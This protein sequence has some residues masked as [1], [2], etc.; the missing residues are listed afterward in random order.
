MV[1]LVII[2]ALLMLFASCVTSSGGDGDTLENTHYTLHKGKTVIHPTPLP[3]ETPIL[4]DWFDTEGNMKTTNG[5]R[6]W[7]FNGDG[8]FEMV[9]VLGTDGIV[10]AR[11]Y[12]FDGD[13]TTDLTKPGP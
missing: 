2:P 1:R 6:G 12:D 4:V 5:F 11:V 8:R 13:G 9:E 7:D 10:Q 3:S